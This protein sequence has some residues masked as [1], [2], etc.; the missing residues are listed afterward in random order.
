MAGKWSEEV[1]KNIFEQKFVIAL[2]YDELG[3]DKIES[4]VYSY[5]IPYSLMED[6]PATFHAMKEGARKAMFEFHEELDVM[7]DEYHRLEDMI[8][9]M[10]NDM[11]HDKRVMYLQEF[12]MGKMCKT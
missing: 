4:K 12:M 11:P 2:R 3:V 5:A 9:R 6:T 1:E 7:R 10:M 8:G